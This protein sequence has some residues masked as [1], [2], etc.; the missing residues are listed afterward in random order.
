MAGF[1]SNLRILNIPNFNSVINWRKISFYLKE[2]LLAAK[3][4]KRNFIVRTEKIRNI[5]ICLNEILKG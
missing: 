3:Q 5:D 2:K 1:I 4:K